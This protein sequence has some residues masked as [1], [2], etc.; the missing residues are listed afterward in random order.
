MQAVSVTLQA[1]FVFPFLTIES[2]GFT[3]FAFLDMK[4]RKER[5]IS[6]GFQIEDFDLLLKSKIQ[7]CFQTMPSSPFRSQ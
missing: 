3:S 2:L 5:V 7:Y 1:I 4:Y 6:S